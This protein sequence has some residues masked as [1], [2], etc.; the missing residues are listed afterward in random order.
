PMGFYSPGQLIQDAQRHGV[1][2]KPISI[3]HSHWESH[4]E[5]FDH[6]KQYIVQLGF[7]R[8]KGLSSKAAQQIIALRQQKQLTSI[9][10]L[11]QRTELSTKELKLLAQA[12][13]LQ[14]LQHTRRQALWQAS[15]PP[16]RDLLQLAPL[17]EPTP[18][19]KPMPEALK[20][21]TDY[22]ATGFRSEERRVGK[23]NK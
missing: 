5:S 4:V 6:K 21:L 18:L 1:M 19:L 3:L 7:N 16:S 12:G 17:A 23:D 2:I 22:Q 14:P 13:V 20:T 11:R 8:L 15:Q 9:D 10:A